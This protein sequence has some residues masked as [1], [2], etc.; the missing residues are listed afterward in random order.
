MAVAVTADM[1]AVTMAVAGMQAAGTAAV[2]AEAGVSAAGTAA[3]AAAAV[4]GSGR[5]S[6]SGS[7][8][9]D[10]CSVGHLPAH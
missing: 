7:P 5:S 8:S 4:T 3:M 6:A 1:V 9:S 10:L 2:A